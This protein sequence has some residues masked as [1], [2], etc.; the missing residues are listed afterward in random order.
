MLNRDIITPKKDLKGGSK[1]LKNKYTYYPL[2]DINKNSYIKRYRLWCKYR[3]KCIEKGKRYVSCKDYA[4]ILNAVGRKV[5]KTIMEDPNGVNFRSFVLKQAFKKSTI[6]K[7]TLV[8]FIHLVKKNKRIEIM[9]FNSW[10]FVPVESYSKELDDKIKN[11]II[12]EFNYEVV[13]RKFVNDS[14]GKQMDIFNDF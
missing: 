8:P 13:Y 2:Y 3:D 11:R 6:N 14:F 4:K 9:S 12:N 7:Q 1:H 10:E 5:K